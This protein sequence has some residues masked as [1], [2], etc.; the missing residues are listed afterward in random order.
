MKY[1]V[2]VSHGGLAEGSNITSHKF[3]AIRWIRS[4]QLTKEGENQLMTAVDFRESISGLTADDSV[5]L[6]RYRG[7]GSPLTTAAHVL[8]KMESLILRMNL[9]YSL[10]AVVWRMTLDIDGQPPFLSEVRSALHS[11][12]KFQPLV[13]EEDD[14]DICGRYLMVNICKDWWPHDSRSDSWHWRSENHVWWFDCRKRCS[15]KQG[16]V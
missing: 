4:S 15:I 12:L 7:G 3:V 11:S 10:T 1:L 13:L 14:D 6:G 16:F 2:L 8:E 5:C 9:T